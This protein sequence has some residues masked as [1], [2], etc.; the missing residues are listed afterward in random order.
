M[1]A[2]TEHMIEEL[3]EKIGDKKVLCALSGG[4]DSA[5][6]AALILFSLFLKYTDKFFSD[7]FSFTLWI[8]DTFKFCQKSFRCII[9]KDADFIMREEIAKA[10][11]DTKIWQ[12]FAVITD[13]KSVGVRNEVR[14]YEYT[15][16]LRAIHSIDAMTAQFVHLPKPS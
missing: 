3:K 12:Y 8:I 15:V 9:L 14:S 13:M 4:V 11:W 5:V 7:N 16:A 2:F 10:G 1:K 6:C